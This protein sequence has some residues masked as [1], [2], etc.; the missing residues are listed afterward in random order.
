MT[1]QINP[2]DP[3][4]LWWCP[5]HWQDGIS[6]NRC[7]ER[8][9]RC[10]LSAVHAD[11]VGRS[12]HIRIVAVGDVLGE[13]HRGQLHQVIGPE[14]HWGPKICARPSRRRRTTS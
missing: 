5:D 13:E 8:A 2:S 3:P 1:K 11:A 7:C 10:W 14:V 4:E 6:R 12:L 9:C